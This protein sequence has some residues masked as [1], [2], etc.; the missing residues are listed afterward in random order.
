MI[1]RI[2]YGDQPTE[3]VVIERGRVV[4]RIRNTRQLIKGR[5]ISKC[6]RNFVRGPVQTRDA[7]DVTCCVVGVCGISTQ[8]VGDTCNKVRS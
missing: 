6:C 3:A 4:Q 8:R 2:G 7:G 5:F 1:E